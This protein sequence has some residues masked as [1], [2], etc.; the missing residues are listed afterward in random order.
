[1]RTLLLL[2]VFPLCSG[3]DAQRILHFTRTS[4][5]DH[6]TRAV[7]FT[8]FQAIANELDLVIDDD[9][10]GDAF[11]DAG[12]LAQYDVIVFSN[13]SGNAILNEQ[14]RA[15]FETWV[16]NGGHVLGI[17]AAS[18][19]YRHSTANGNNTGTWDFYAEL[20]GGSVQ[21][22]PNHV[23]GTPQYTMELVG[24]HAS[25][26]NLPDPWVKNEEFYYWQG[27]YYGPDNT[28]VLRVE[29]TV[30]PNGQVNSYDAPRPMSWYRMLPNGSRVFYTA[31]GHAPDNYTSDMLFRTHI[32]DALEWLLEGTTGVSTI[33]G[34]VE[35]RV[36]PVPA[37]EA[38]TIV[39]DAMWTGMPVQ[40]L[41][42]TGR[43]VQRTTITGER[44]T[45]MIH[46]LPAGAYMV[47]TPG[48]A[49]PVHI[50]R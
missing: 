44:T 19:T 31:L 48:A 5:W 35:L 8:M 15:N 22:N 6:Q 21:E 28:E 11:S 36:F 23:A 34:V 13:T 46:T 27:G 50:L 18:D 2:L 17:H 12:N 43:V 7:S 10:S 25:T 40:L 37:S 16:S 26:A 38:L 29:E 45:I 49:R 41:D 24:A 33:D 42:A 39:T 1:M 30:G 3:L 32:K 20:L 9:A 4:G 14:Q 47:R